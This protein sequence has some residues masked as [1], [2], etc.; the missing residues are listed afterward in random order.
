MGQEAEE[1]R[2]FLCDWIFW[3][4]KVRGRHLSKSM[5]KDFRHYSV[6]SPLKKR[7]PALYQPLQSKRAGAACPYVKASNSLPLMPREAHEL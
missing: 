4:G 1:L 2:C 7:W 3:M 5:R 6:M